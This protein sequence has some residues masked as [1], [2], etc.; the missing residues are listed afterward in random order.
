MKK[1]TKFAVTFAL[2]LALLLSSV[3]TSYAASGTK[4]MTLYTDV[5]KSGKYAY[6]CTYN[7]IYRVNLKTK[8]VKQIL[9][10]DGTFDV[11]PP[12]SM[13]LYKGYIYY[14]T[15]APMGSTLGRVK[16][17]GKNNRLLASIW[18]YAISKNKIYYTGYDFENENP[19]GIKRVMSLNGK[20]EKK[21]SYE[22]INKY[23]RS[24]KKGYK[25]I[26]KIK[27]I[28]EYESIDTYYLVT[29]NKKKIKLGKRVVY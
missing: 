6:C 1:K 25:V 9:K 19:D 17:N 5:I 27:P 22:V 20:N 2:V 16:T 7:G 13:K 14:T 12:D 29:P 15:A 28:D 23:K 18:D 21:C 10:D 3:V 8:K 24:N 4:K 11:N 26:T